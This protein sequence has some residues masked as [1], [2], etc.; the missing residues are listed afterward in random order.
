M[1][2]TS[3]KRGPHAA[4]SRRHTIRLLPI[5]L[6]ASVMG[7]TGLSLAWREAAML[8]ILDGLA[9]EMIGWVGVFVFLILT[10]SYGVKF[11]LHPSAIMAEYTHPVLNNF[12]AT[13]AIGM[14]LLSAFLRPYNAMIGD[15]VWVCGTALA[16]LIAYTVM[17]RFTGR[18]HDGK[19]TLPAL[20]IPGVATLDI[21]VTG[22]TLPFSW[23]HEINLLA[24]AV[25]SVLASVLIVLIFSRLRHHEA[26]PLP[27]RPSLLILV[28][29]FAVGFLA[30]TNL[31]GEVDMFASSL[32]YFA[33]FLLLLLA[34]QV[35]R[36]GIPF[37]VN[38]WAIGFPLAA[39]SLASFRYSSAVQSWPLQIFAVAMFIALAA[40][41]A[42]LFL[43]TLA[44]ALTGRLF[45]LENAA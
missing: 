12:F 34:P 16:F 38:W 37:S 41:I 8:Q 45:R 24:F 28:A 18:Q 1:A 2:E 14:L 19:D 21:T 31:T 32:F 36:A 3:L 5:N 43:K 25:G 27:M 33:L 17:R 10:V 9:G 23:A 30:Y 13:I 4:K 39:F 15:A 6:F 20:L 40:A 29:P 42:V 44:I 7:I 26:I 11:A 35:F 22:S